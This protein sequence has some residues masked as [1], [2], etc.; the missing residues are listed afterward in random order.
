[1]DEDRQRCAAAGM[2]DYISKPVE[3]EELRRLIL[4]WAEIPGTKP[5]ESKAS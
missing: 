1:M 4:Q 2:N 3:E 5:T